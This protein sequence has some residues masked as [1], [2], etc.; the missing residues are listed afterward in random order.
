MR[1]SAVGPDR[2]D[3]PQHLINRGVSA[4]ASSALLKRG[5][6]NRAWKAALQPA[7]RYGTEFLRRTTPAELLRTERQYQC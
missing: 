1:S 5:R 3:A 7:H 6:R 4:A 2:A